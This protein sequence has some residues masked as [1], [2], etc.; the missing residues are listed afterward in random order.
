MTSKITKA[1][2]LLSFTLFI[3]C[4]QKDPNKQIDEGSVKGELYKS[5]DIGWSI[6]IPKGWSVVSKD[7]IDQNEEKGQKAIEKTTGQK[8]DT[9]HLKHLISF[10]KNQ[11]NFFASTSEPFKEEY[12]GEYQKNS[13][14]LQHLIY[15]TY[16]DNHIKADSSSGKEIIDGIEFNTFYT[17]IYAPGGDRVIL[18]QIMYNKLIN[19]YDFGVNINYN[20][21]EDKKVMMEAFKKSKFQT[22]KLKK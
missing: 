20:N 13:K 16:L 12:P 2:L 10:Q 5:S 3:A 11:F 21:E 4:G 22:S 8:F 7:Q 6:E 9:Q 18:N 14:M 1:A 15:Q 19:G 17:T